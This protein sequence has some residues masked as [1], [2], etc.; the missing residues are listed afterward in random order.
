MK[1]DNATG[2]RKLLEEQVE[3]MYYAEKQLVK[4]LSK[5]SLAATN[6]ELKDAF[7]WHLEETK[8]HVER[9]E[10]VFAILGK[11]PQVKK[12]PAIDGIILEGSEIME[13]YKD[14]PALDAGLV[15]A[16]RKAEHY[17]IA[18]YGFMCEWAKELGLTAAEDLLHQTLEEE[19][20]ADETLTSIAINS[21]NVVSEGA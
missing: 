13:R 17:E 3:D 4:A 9:L 20:S 1:E 14:D 8:G 7:A 12:C 18:T 15:A 21:V 2:L 16:G 5:L 11:T 10:Q 6:G 19:K